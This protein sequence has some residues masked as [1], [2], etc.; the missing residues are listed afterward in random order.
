MF[1][2]IPPNQD[3]P[4]AVLFTLQKVEWSDIHKSFSDLQCILLLSLW[5]IPR[6][7]SGLMITEVSLGMDSLVLI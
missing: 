4:V 1:D 5:G 3:F 7:L 2:T 6:S